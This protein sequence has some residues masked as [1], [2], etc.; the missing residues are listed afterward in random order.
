MAQQVRR[1]CAVSAQPFRYDRAAI[2]LRLRSNLV[3]ISQL[4]RCDYAA[5]SL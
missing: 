4:F 2:S 3:E 5:I 1:E